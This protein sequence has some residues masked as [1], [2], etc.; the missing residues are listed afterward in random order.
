MSFV[1]RQM[2]R[3]SQPPFMPTAFDSPM[4]LKWPKNDRDRLEHSVSKLGVFYRD[5]MA[6]KNIN[7]TGLTLVSSE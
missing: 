4:K 6:E 2:P 3:E 1:V 5:Q 7:P